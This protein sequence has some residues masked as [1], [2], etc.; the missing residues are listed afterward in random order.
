MCALIQQRTIVR[1]GVLY[2]S[3]S[4]RE[5][6]DL[7]IIVFASRKA[8]TYYESLKT[9]V[10]RSFFGYAQ[11]FYEFDLVETVQIEYERQEIYRY[12]RPDITQYSSLKCDLLRLSN[13]VKAG[14]ISQGTPIVG[15]PDE[16]LQLPL[17]RCPLTKV[18]IRCYDNSTIQI[19][20]F[21]EALLGD[22]ATEVQW[23]EPS[24]REDEFVWNSVVANPELNEDFPSLPYDGVDDSGETYVPEVEGK[25]LWTVINGQGRNPSTCEPL[26]NLGEYSYKGNITLVLENHPAGGNCLVA[27]MYKDGIALS[28]AESFYPGATIRYEYR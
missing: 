7:Q 6:T 11:F 4:E 8:D 12:S 21:G 25:E 1:D 5:K 20:A 2:L 22:C 15:L 18:R 26:P 3:D 28:W 14:F 9:P 24:R 23:Q 13:T 19:A 17:D 27:H 16:V 10:P